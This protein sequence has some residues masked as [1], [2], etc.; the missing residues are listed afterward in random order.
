MLRMYPG[1]HQQ[2]IKQHNRLPPLEGNHYQV[3]SNILVLGRLK[4][5][6]CRESGRSSDFIA[7]SLANGCF[8]ACA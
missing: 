4:T 3:K 5:L 7:P 1:A 2:E 8:G 6:V